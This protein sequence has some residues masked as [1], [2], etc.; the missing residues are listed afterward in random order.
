MSEEQRLLLKNGLVV[1]GTGNTA[2]N[3]DVLI[4][5]SRIEAV[6][7]APIET[8]STSMD[9]TGL[10]VA[11]GFIDMHS[12]MDW[13]FRPDKGAAADDSLHDPDPRRADP[14]RCFRSQAN[15]L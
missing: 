4:N 7:E 10:V 12:H 13:R 8:E 14:H 3:G 11:P 6:S 1:D 2:F 5:G 9:C 15:F